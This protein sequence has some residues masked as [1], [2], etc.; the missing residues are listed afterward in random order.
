MMRNIEQDFDTR[1]HEKLGGYVYALRDPRNGAVF[2]IGKAG[3]WDAQGND[4]VLAHFFRARLCQKDPQLE[5]SSKIKRIIEIWESGYDVEWFIVRRG[6]RSKDEAFH[7]EAALIDLLKYSSAPDALNEINGIW[8]EE[9]GPL[10]AAGVRLLAAPKLGANAVPIELAGRPILIF[11][12]Q[13]AIAG[14]RDVD[15]YAATRR[16][17][18]LGHGVRNVAQAIAVGVAGGISR[19]AWEVE[20]WARDADDPKRWC[21]T[22]RELQTRILHNLFPRNFHA[23]ILHESVRGYWQYGNAIAI[24]LSEN[25]QFRVIRGS[26]DRE[27]HNCVAAS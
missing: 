21:F 15:A 23:V 16:A 2:Y 4:R 14:K 7:I 12:I 22:G 27:W 3:G 9:H 5:R 8:R 25:G 10:D 17:W 26:S 6:L 24:E 13:N 19:G 11:N 18:K 20:S 1:I